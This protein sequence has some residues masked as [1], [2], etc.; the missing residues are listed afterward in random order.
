MHQKV[1]VNLL[2][3]E[4]DEVKNIQD[5]LDPVLELAI[6]VFEFNLAKHNKNKWYVNGV[7]TKHIIG[8]G[9]MLIEFKKKMAVL[10]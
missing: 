10:K 1:V 4:N 3:N 6:D 7:V 8:N 9:D 5:Y 2:K